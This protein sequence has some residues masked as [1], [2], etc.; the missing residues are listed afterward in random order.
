MKFYKVTHI[1]D[2]PDMPYVFISKE[3]DLAMTVGW[4]IEDEIIELGDKLI[5][6]RIDCDE[7]YFDSLKESEG[8]E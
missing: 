5:I 8:I 7:D 3:I 1:Q 4:I 2:N 6:E